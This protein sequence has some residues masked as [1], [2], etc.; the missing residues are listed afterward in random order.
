MDAGRVSRVI[1]VFSNSSLLCACL[2]TSLSG[3]LTTP[4]FLVTPLFH[5]SPT[6]DNR[7]TFVCDVYVTMFYPVHILV[8]LKDLTTSSSVIM[9]FLNWVIPLNYT[10]ITEKTRLI[11]SKTGLI[12]WQ[13]HVDK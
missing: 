2:D 5:R 8:I 11:S 10:S 7:Y 13:I 12:P 4:A 3:S 6:T 9:K 1:F